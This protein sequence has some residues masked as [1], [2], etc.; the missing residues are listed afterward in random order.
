MSNVVLAESMADSMRSELVVGTIKQAMKR[1]HLPEGI[2]FPSDWGSQ[3]T[4]EAVMK[5]VEE[6]RT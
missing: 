1:W 2:I 4:S 3:Y 5:L 6:I